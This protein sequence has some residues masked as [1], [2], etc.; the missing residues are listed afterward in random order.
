MRAWMEATLPPEGS[1]PRVRPEGGFIS[2]ERRPRGARRP[3]PGV[4]ARGGGE[5]LALEPAWCQEGLGGVFPRVVEGERVMWFCRDAGGAER[6]APPM[7]PG[8]RQAPLGCGL[9]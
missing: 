9:L 8:A 1:A 7:R 2:G 6:G 5:K 4:G 3:R